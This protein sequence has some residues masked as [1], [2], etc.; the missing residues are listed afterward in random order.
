MDAPRFKEEKMTV[1][2]HKI[3]PVGEDEYGDVYCVAVY[4]RGYVDWFKL[5][6]S[7]DFF[8]ELAPPTL[9]DEEV[10][11]LLGGDEWILQIPKQWSSTSAEL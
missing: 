1:E 4:A 10:Q 9:K 7:L 2:P 6:A 11:S 5:Y 8:D 3:Y